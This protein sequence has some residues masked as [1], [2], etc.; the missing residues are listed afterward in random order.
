MCIVFYIFAKT[1]PHVSHSD[2]NHAKMSPMLFSLSYSPSFA[3]FYY[4]EIIFVHL[5]RFIANRRNKKNRPLAGSFCSVQ[6][7]CFM[8]SVAVS[9]S[10]L[11]VTVNF[12]PFSSL[13][14]SSQ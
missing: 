3:E 2:V 10:A 9:S 1:Q 6:M 8:P 12:T 14:R 11:M 13:K 7:Y 4:F 5:V